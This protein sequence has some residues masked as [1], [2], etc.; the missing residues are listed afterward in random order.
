[1]T[2]TI[3]ARTLMKALELCDDGGDRNVEY[4]PPSENFGRC[5]AMWS[6]YFGQQFTARDVAMMMALLKI[7]RIAANPNGAS[8][9]S[10]IDLAA[11]AS[12]SAEL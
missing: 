5:A 2:E 11:Y 6:A 7:S 1:M 10:F 12:I 4:G 3:R 8:M 9:D